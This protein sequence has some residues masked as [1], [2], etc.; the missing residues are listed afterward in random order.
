[1]DVDSLNVSKH[2]VL[3]HGNRP[4]SNCVSSHN[5]YT[6]GNLIIAHGV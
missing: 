6:P 2:D 4:Q 3:N 5:P 1:M